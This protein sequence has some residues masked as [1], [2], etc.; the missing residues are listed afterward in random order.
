MVGKWMTLFI[1]LFGAIGPAVVYWYGGMLVIQGRLSLA[2]HR[3]R[4]R[5]TG[6]YRPVTRLAG[7][8]TSIQEA[9]GVFGRIIHW[10]TASRKR[11]TC[12]MRSISAPSAAK[13]NSIM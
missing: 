11:A 13:S 4:R 7:V 10:L 8:Y 12:L 1:A 2:R 6:L 9:M 3:F 5:L